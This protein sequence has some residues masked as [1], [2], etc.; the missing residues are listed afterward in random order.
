[1]K[2]LVQRFLDLVLS[3]YLYNEWRG[4]VQMET[5]LIPQLEAN[6]RMDREFIAA[7]K[8][9]CADEKKHYHMFKGYFVSRGRMPFAVGKSIGYFDALTGVL[10]GRKAELSTDED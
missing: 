2:S 9:H 3:V 7:V 8:K 4:Y 5:T 10:L 6:P 1:M